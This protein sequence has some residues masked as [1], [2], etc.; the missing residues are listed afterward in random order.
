VSGCRDF[1]PFGGTKEDGG[2]AVA[3]SDAQGAPGSWVFK[4]VSMDYAA[5]GLGPPADPNV[6]LWDPEANLIRMFVTHWPN[7][8]DNTSTTYSYTSTDGFTFSYEG[9]RYNPGFILD[10]ENFRFDASNWQIITAS[11]NGYAISTDDGSTFTNHGPFRDH[12]TN[13]TSYTGVPSDI[14]VTGTS[15]V[16]RIFAT[17]NGGP[18]SMGNIDSLVSTASPWTSWQ[19]EGTALEESPGMESCGVSCPTVVRL[20]ADSWLMF[21][22]TVNP[23][24]EC[25]GP[26]PTFHCSPP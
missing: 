1:T 9:P 16:Y 11:D 24:C 17:A 5:H 21:Y 12:V 10:P 7:W 14:A 15:G 23:N 22:M 20:A 13:S 2:M 18:T 4:D 3:I 26:G 8:P 19:L 6:V 25:G